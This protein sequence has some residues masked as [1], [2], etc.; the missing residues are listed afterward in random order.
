[1]GDPEV[2][3]LGMCK[4]SV[5]HN[6]NTLWL[7]GT[8]RLC[9]TPWIQRKS[10]KD[11]DVR[12]QTK[13]SL[14][15]T[16]VSCFGRFLPNAFQFKSTN[17]P[18]ILRQSLRGKQSYNKS[19]NDILYERCT[20]HC[21]HSNGKVTAGHC[22]WQYR[23]TL[24]ERPISSLMDLSYQLCKLSKV[25]SG[26]LDE[27]RIALFCLYVLRPNVFASSVTLNTVCTVRSLNRRHRQPT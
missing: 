3:S 1:M 13:R 9:L 14:I 2:A 25:Y 8:S 6:R 18:G 23:L 5:Y 17:C 20:S 12:S 15:L 24:I 27:A 4:M 19:L 7:C 16:N 26:V 21:S 22:T 10:V 11:T